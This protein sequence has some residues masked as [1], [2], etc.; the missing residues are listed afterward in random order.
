MKRLF[1]LLALLPLIALAQ[2]VNP[3]A[4]V[5]WVAPT[6]N[7]DNSPITAALTYNLY[8][9]TSCTAL[10]KIQSAITTT[11]TTVSSSTTLVPGTT[12]CFAVTAVANA[13]ESGKSNTATL[14]IPFPTPGAP[15]QIT[16]V[17][18]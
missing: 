6:Q 1:A 8:A 17:I 7:T 15:S 3:T 2:A 4:T 18:H 5:T 10:S 9:G 11:S 13:V 14:A 16:V 12:Y